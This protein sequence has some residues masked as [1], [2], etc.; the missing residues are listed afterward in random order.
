VTRT[1]GPRW[2]RAPGRV[3]PRPDLQRRIQFAGRRIRV[4]T[5]WVLQFGVVTS[6]AACGPPGVERE[7]DTAI[8]IEY[9]ISPTPP[10]VGPAQ[11]WARVRDGG[12][13]APTSA[14]VQVR[15][16][17]ADGSAGPEVTLE[18]DSSGLWTGTVPFPSSGEGMLQFRVGLADA[19]RAT[20]RHPVSVSRRPGAS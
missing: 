15:M 5:L 17:D 8:E 12:R 3:A 7:G 14:T 19:R 13:A 6:L 1:V 4:P 2:G 10:M 9:G 16:F 18:P 20:I 11:V